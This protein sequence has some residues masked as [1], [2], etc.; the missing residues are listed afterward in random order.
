MAKNLYEIASNVVDFMERQYFSSELAFPESKWDPNAYDGDGR[1]LAEST[2]E[3]APDLPEELLSHPAFPKP[4]LRQLLSRSRFI[5]GTEGGAKTLMALIGVQGRIYPGWRVID[6]KSRHAENAANL[7]TEETSYLTSFN[8]DFPDT[9]V[10]ASD[11]ANLFVHVERTSG[12]SPLNSLSLDQ[13]QTENF[14]KETITKFQWLGTNVVFLANLDTSYTNI[15]VRDV[16]TWEHITMENGER[17]SGA[18]GRLRGRADDRT[19]SRGNGNGRSRHLQGRSEIRSGRRTGI[20]RRR[21]RRQT[22]R[23]ILHRSGLRRKTT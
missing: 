18:G 21:R 22:G 19:R 5:K 1:V 14:I 10:A 7:D 3:L 23:R 17:K 15:V 9:T 4:F 8:R 6:L 12:S 11:G 13:L 16:L 2:K 20:R